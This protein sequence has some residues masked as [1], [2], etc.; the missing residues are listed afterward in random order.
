MVQG[1]YGS[2]SHKTTQNK[3]RSKDQWYRIEGTH[4]P[5]IDRDLWGKVNPLTEQKNKAL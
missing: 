4:E 2:I 3:P 5:I 1:K